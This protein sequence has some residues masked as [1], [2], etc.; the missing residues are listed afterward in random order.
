MAAVSYESHPRGGQVA[1]ITI[2]ADT[3]PWVL[4]PTDNVGLDLSVTSGTA[5]VEQTAA[6][7]SEVAAATAVAFSWSNG[8]IAAGVKSSSLLVG[9][10]A[11]RLTGT[12]VA[13]LSVR[14]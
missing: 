11:V 14:F 13:K 6:S 9:A 12:G 8:A 10:S 1:T 7:P 5:T 4:I 3:S 2:S